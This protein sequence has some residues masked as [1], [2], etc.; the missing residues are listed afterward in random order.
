MLVLVAST[1]RHFI[2]Y[3]FTFVYHCSLHTV[4]TTKP[5]PADAKKKKILLQHISEGKHITHDRCLLQIV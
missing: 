3:S 4:S 5:P 1:N 2:G